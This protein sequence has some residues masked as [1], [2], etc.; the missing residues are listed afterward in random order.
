MNKFRNAGRRGYA[1]I[2]S[3][4]TVHTSRTPIM[5]DDGKKVD[6]W[7]GH[8]FFAK[9]PSRLEHSARMTAKKYARR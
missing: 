3:G 6:G 8:T 7:I 1:K 4:R 2:A 9:W 5:S